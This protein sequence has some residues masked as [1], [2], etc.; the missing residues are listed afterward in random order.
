[1]IIRMDTFVIIKSAAISIPITLRFMVKTPLF[2][3]HT[4]L[5]KAHVEAPVGGSIVLA[6]VLLKL[7]SYGL[8][9]FLPLIKFNSLLA[10]Y[11]SLT[12]TGSIVSSLI[13]LRIGDL[14]ILIAYSSVVH[15]RI[16][17]LGIL[18]GTEAGYSCALMMAIS[19]GLISPF[20]FA[21]SYWLYENSHS[22][23]MLNN[24]GTWPVIMGAMISLIALNMRV[25][26][27]IGL[28]SE[29]LIFI[30]SIHLISHSIYILILMIFLTAAYNL[31]LYIRCIH[32]KFRETQKDLPLIC[33]FPLI[34]VVYS[35]HFSY[36][37]LDLFHISIYHV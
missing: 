26:P 8:I 4:W 25:P 20:L 12:L 36:L 9:I 22:R 34:Q 13:C 37:C 2:L 32:S 35:S 27:R 19:H 1:M 11:L 15:I 7:G 30:I 17:T 31:Y 3:L 28:W 21:F 29:V 24:T 33:Y 23:L 5:P 16:V 18:R 14:K 6:R 10:L